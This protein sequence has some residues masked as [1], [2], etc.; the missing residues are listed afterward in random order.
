VSLAVLGIAGSLRAASYSRG[1]LRAAQELAPPGMEIR[2]LDLA[3]VPLY[4]ADVEKQGAPAAVAE[5]KQAIQDADCLLVATPEYN[6]GIPG[7]LKNAIDWASRPDGRSVLRHKPVGLM[8]GSAGSGA[9]IRAQLQLRQVL[10]ATE[11]PVLLRPEVLIPR[12]QEK[13]DASGRLADEKT[14]GLVQGLLVALQKWALEIAT[15]RA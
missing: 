5:L 12:V 8:G 14:R 3:G 4:N 6:Y 10:L 2:I 9:T 11:T 13:F 7:V 1:L 15:P